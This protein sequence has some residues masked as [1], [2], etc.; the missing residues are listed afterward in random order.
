MKATMPAILRSRTSSE[1]TSSG[2]HSDYLRVGYGSIVIYH[3][4]KFGLFIIG[5]LKYDIR[6]L[7]LN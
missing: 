1:M 6:S 7:I 3:S 2:A 5:M 4:G